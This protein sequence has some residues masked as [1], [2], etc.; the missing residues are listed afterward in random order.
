[1]F[2]LF[3]AISSIISLIIVVILHIK[4]PVVILS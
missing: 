4:R 2:K 1:M 3:T